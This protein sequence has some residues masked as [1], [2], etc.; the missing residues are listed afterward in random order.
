MGIL[1]HLFRSSEAVARETQTEDESIIKKWREYIATIPAKKTVI[2]RLNTNAKFPDDLLKLRRLLSLELVDI[3]DETRDESAL[4][5][6]LEALEHSQKV[7]RVHKLEQCLGYA[8]TRYQYVYSLLQEL[9][10]ILKSEMHI[11]EKLLAKSK[12]AKRLV[13]HLR[14][15]L[16]LELEII[17]KIEQIRTFHNLFLELVKGE[18]IIRVMDSSEKRLLRKM[19]E[20]MKKIFSDEI[21]GITYEWAMTVFKGIKDKVHEGVANGMFDSYHPDIDFEFANRPEF[22]DLVRE[23]IQKL[24]KRKVSEQMINVFVHLFREWYNHERD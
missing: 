7:K 13:S 24:R 14:S 22:V 10:S 6:D 18:H 12:K 17:K 8:E 3:S 15:Q 4:I 23:S 16:E 5:S 2:G 11:I 9:H 19:Q 20:G 1:N 21:S